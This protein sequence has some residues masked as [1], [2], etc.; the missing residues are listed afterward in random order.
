MSDSTTVYTAHAQKRCTRETCHDNTVP[1]FRYEG[2]V[3]EFDTPEARS[4]FIASMA[5]ETWAA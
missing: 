1:Y 3:A 2:P 4:Q 5:P